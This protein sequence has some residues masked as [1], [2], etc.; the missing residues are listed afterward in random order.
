MKMQTLYVPVLTIIGVCL[1][2]LIFEQPRDVEAGKLEKNIRTIP[3]PLLT[4]NDDK[5]GE[6]YL[7]LRW[8]ECRRVRSASGES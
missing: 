7:S 4:N 2:E 3:G 6:R 8:P 5:K 1:I